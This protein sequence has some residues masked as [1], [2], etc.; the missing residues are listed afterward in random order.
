MKKLSRGLNEVDTKVKRL[1]VKYNKTLEEKAMLTIELTKAEET[2][3]NAETLVGKLEGEFQRWSGQVVPLLLSCFLMF[4]WEYLLSCFERMLLTKTSTR[5]SLF[6]GLMKPRTAKTVCDCKC[7]VHRGCLRAWS[8][9]I[10]YW[11]YRILP[12]F[13]PGQTCKH[14][15]MWNSVTQHFME[16]YLLQVLWWILGRWADNWV[17]GAADEDLARLW[18]HDLLVGSAWRC[19]PQY[20]SQVDQRNRHSILWPAE[21]AILSFS[22]LFI[23]FLCRRLFFL[24]L[25]FNIFALALS[26]CCLQAKLQ[27]S[28]PHEDKI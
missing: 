2:I 22:A 1:E 12:I 8:M 7:C 15:F 13:Y 14:M 25:L 17:E 27:S 9:S 18:I 21:V 26:P 6:H 11:F 28:F 19:S 16:I 5:R 3:A 10:S 20:D 4:G 23:H 24:I